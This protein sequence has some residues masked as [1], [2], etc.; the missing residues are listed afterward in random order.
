MSAIQNISLYIPHIYANYTSARVFDIIENMRIGEIKRVDFV[1]KTGSDGKPYNAA[2]IHFYQWYDNI[3]AH[4]FQERVLNPAQEARIMYDDPWYWIVLENKG[5]KHVPGER[6]PR[7][8]LDAFNDSIVNH[9]PTAGF[10]GGH[11]HEKEVAKPS[12]YMSPIQFKKAAMDVIYAPKKAK[13]WANV[14]QPAPTPVK[15]ENVFNAEAQ[16]ADNDLTQEEMD[17]AYEQME[18][19]Q[20][21][22]DM[23]AEMKMDDMYLSTFDTRYVQTLEQECEMLRSQVAYLQN[24]YYTETIK[25]QTLADTIKNLKE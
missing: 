5:K 8:D 7:I 25:S 11:T 15:L 10:D 6:K 24:L 14:V 3:V 9:K 12:N 21:L 1:P 16:A 19:E 22:A 20:M 2:Y 17:W 23:E 4:N 18:D 13:S